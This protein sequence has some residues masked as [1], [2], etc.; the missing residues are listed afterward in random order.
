MSYTEIK[1]K[2]QYEDC[3]LVLERLLETDPYGQ[4]DQ[5]EALTGMIRAWDDAMHPQEVAH[6]PIVLLRLL[7]KEHGLRNGDLADL[8]GLSKGAMSNIL[9]YR[10]NFSKT[11][12]RVLASHF[13]ITQES[14]DRPYALRGEGSHVKSVSASR[15]RKKVK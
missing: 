10:R 15:E 8:L 5:I 11:H 3:C 13:A 12:I 1:S 2:A 9:H 7:M 6:D 4:V 14:L